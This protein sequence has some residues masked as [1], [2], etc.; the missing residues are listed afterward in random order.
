MDWITIKY[1]PAYSC[2]SQEIVGRCN[3]GFGPSRP[4]GFLP[5]LSPAWLVSHQLHWG[6][7]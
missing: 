7:H 5:L 6:A 1:E 2:L 4:V 3:V